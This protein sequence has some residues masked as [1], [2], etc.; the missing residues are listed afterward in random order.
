MTT[1]TFQVPDPPTP[2]VSCPPPTILGPTLVHGFPTWAI[3]WGLVAAVV[4]A[5]ALIIA[6]YSSRSQSRA[7]HSKNRQAE[8]NAQVDIAMH[9]KVCTTCGAS[10]D[11]EISRKEKD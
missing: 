10:Y 2:Q 11:P 3:A 5:L 4:V 7:L 8:L 6:I 9:H 1:V